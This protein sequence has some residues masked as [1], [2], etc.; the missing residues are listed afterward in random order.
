MSRSEER[1]SGEERCGRALVQRSGR[2]WLPVQMSDQSVNW[3]GGEDAA[4]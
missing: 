2:G 1:R 3:F 4:L